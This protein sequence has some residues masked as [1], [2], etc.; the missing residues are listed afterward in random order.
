MRGKWLLLSG[1]LILLAV[2]AGTLSVLRKPAPP[3]PPKQEEVRGPQ[4]GDEISMP[5]KIQAAHIV[6]IAAPVDGTLD[7]WLV[8]AGQE[9]LEEQELGHVTNAG[10]ESAQ[11]QAQEE[12]DRVQ[13]RISN[14]EAS[15]LAGK[16]EAARTESDAA[17]AK[18][19]AARL[20]K[21]YAREQLLYREGATARLKFE[22]AE[23]EY[24]V[25]QEEA[26]NA[27]ELSRQAAERIAKIEK[28]LDLARKV[29][30]DK[31][32]ALEDAKE[33]L[34]AAVI[35]SPAEGLILK[36]AVDAGAEV[37]RNM[38]DLVQIAVDPAL[39]EIVVEPEPPI[40]ERLQTGQPALVTVPEAGPEAMQGQIKEIKETQVTVEFT[41]PTPAVKHGMT[42][43]VKFRLI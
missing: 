43:S 18:S 20:E 27:A 16:L 21:L 42:G 40:R 22:K 23:K 35:V 41:S 32:T 3:P 13:S 31:Q 8:E 2:A 25:A 33:D 30:D 10:L 6:A 26:N 17:R 24:K 5:G 9:V 28:D 36:L 7:T 29:L 1:T 15:I 37:D 14:L 34:K 39:L 4:A 19:E 12:L 38:R 11:E